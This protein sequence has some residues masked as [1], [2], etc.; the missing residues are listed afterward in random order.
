MRW[1]VAAGRKTMV[2]AHLLHR[3][4]QQRHWTEACDDYTLGQIL[5][6]LDL[7][8]S[9]ARMTKRVLRTVR[10]KPEKLDS[11]HKLEVELE[12]VNYSF[13]DGSSPS[14]SRVESE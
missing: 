9:P 13:P 5:I 8:S 7:T 12:L 11:F 2:L 3:P 14:L 6:Q 10:I 4:Q 1:G